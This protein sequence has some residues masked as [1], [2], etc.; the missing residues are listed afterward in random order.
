LP[1][2]RRSQDA[3]A[4]NRTEFDLSDPLRLA[5]CLIAFEVDLIINSAACTAVDLAEEE[6]ALAFRINA[7]PPVELVRWAA[8]HDVPLIHFST[9]YVF[10][11]S[12]ETA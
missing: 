4:P 1:L 9:D 10:D 5:S 6:P 11:G 2:L 12:G 7:E 3:L 8:R